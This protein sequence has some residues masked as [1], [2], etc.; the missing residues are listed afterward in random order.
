MATPENSNGWKRRPSQSDM[1]LRY[2][3][4]RAGPKGHAPAII[5]SHDVEGAY[6]HYYR[7]RSQKCLPENCESCEANIERRWRGYLIV[8]DARTR[9]TSMMEVTAAAM[10]DIDRYFREHRTLRGALIETRRIPPKANGRLVS[11]LTESAYDMA[12]YNKAP[13]LRKLLMKLWGLH[14]AD[15]ENPDVMRKIRLAAT[16]PEA[17]SA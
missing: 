5:L 6:I 1:P 12:S 7:G 13:P 14:D 16:D 10:P 15:Q 4:N 17:K 3:V 2:E 8:A 9:E 11:K